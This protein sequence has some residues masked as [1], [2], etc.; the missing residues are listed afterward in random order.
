M[1]QFAQFFSRRPVSL[2][3]LLIILIW[4][5][6]L[7]LG[8]GLVPHDPVAQDIDGR[9]QLP[10][11]EHPF[12][13][14][15]L[16]RDILSRVLSGGRV[17][18]PA[19]FSVVV[20]GGVVGTILGSIAGYWGRWLDN[21]LMRITDLFF[22]FPP[23]ILALAIGVALGANL[24]MAIIAIV[25]VWWPPYARMARAVVQS[26][27][28]REFVEASR[29]IGA[30]DWRIL[31]RTILPNAVTPIIVMGA[32]DLGNGIIIVAIFSFLGL[33]VQPPTPEWGAMVA[34]GASLVDKW[35]IS[36]FPVLAITSVT[37]A[38]NLLGDGVRDFLD[39]H[40]RKETTKM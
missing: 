31:R 2:V 3:G 37:M 13:T 10:N 25:F 7:L 21:L 4:I 1:L 5:F 38:C 34:R 28:G 19:G 8:P 39:P 17:S 16:G 26:L 23:M 30:S 40:L 9:Y 15:D 27:K 24:Y 29:V 35:W 14:D 11:S 12:G 22:A 20:V 33:G 32:L 36:L 6:L 18:V